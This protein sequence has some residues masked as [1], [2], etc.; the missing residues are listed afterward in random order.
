MSVF[1]KPKAKWQ[2]MYKWLAGFTV[3]SKRSKHNEKCSQAQG[4]MTAYPCTL[5]CITKD[6]DHPMVQQQR[7]NYQ[8]ER[9]NDTYG[10]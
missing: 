7:T 10:N 5:A 4:Q 9:G 3:A 6:S 2:L 8:V 1:H